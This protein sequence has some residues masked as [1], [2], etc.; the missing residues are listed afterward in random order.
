MK[1]MMRMIQQCVSVFR[2]KKINKMYTIKEK[3]NVHDGCKI[4]ILLHEFFMYIHI[5][6]RSVHCCKCIFIACVRAA[7]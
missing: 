7:L 1:F 2:Y 4:T 5:W 3:C 6:M